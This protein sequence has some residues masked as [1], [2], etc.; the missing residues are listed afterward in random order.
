MSLYKL[1]QQTEKHKARTWYRNTGE[2]TQNRVKKG[3]VHAHTYTLGD[4]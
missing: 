3:L 1:M 4:W 2:A